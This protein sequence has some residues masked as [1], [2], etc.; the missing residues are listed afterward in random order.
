[1]SREVSPLQQY[2]HRTIDLQV[3][4]A[5]LELLSRTDTNNTPVK[6]EAAGEDSVTTVG[7][8]RCSADMRAVSLYEPSSVCLQ[9]NTP[10]DTGTYILLE[11]YEF[12]AESG[13]WQVYE[14][15]LRGSDKRAEL[16]KG[17][18]GQQ[19]VSELERSITGARHLFADELAES[20][21]S[22]ARIANIFRQ[23][24]LVPALM[25]LDV[26]HIPPEVLRTEQE[27]DAVPSADHE[28]DVS[29][30]DDL[31]NT[32]LQ[33]LTENEMSYA[34]AVVFYGEHGERCEVYKNREGAVIS[35]HCE[36]QPVDGVSANVQRVVDL[37]LI[38]DVFHC[39]EALQ[40]IDS[41]SVRS[42]RSTP[43]V[44][45]FTTA[46]D[47]MTIAHNADSIDELTL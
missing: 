40:A 11:G 47:I 19:H 22:F 44:L 35:V 34:G 37:T 13:A 32:L 3:D 12:H 43:E 33:I 4:A 23:L 2:E 30:S 10:R 15:I 25:S 46:C 5:I 38:G 9:F 31:S 29:P 24:K 18:L 21:R 1:M 28:T 16:H 27:I 41:T 17:V 6:I 39:T 36:F 45:S 26:L 8:S 7:F 20:T 42:E 14:R